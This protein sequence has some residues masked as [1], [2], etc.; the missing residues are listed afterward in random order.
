MRT[1]LRRAPERPIRS[2]RSCVRAPPRRRALTSAPGRTPVCAGDC[3]CSQPAREEQPRVRPDRQLPLPQDPRGRLQDLHLL[4]PARRRGERPRWRRAPAFRHEGDPGKPAP[5]RGRPHRQEGRYRGRKG[6]AREPRQG[7]GRD[8]LP[9]GSRADAGL[10]RR[11]GGGRP[12]GHARRHEDA[13]RRP[14][15]HQPA[16]P[17]RPRDRPL[18]HRGRVRHAQGLREECRARIRA[19]HGALQ[20]PEMGSGRLRELLGR[21]ARHRHLPPGQ[22][23]IP[24]ADRV[25]QAL[26]GGRDRARLPG[27]ARRHGLAHHDG[28]RARRA[29]LGRRRDRGRGRDAGPADLDADP[30]G[31][32]VQA[33]GE[34]ARG[35]DGDGPRAHRHPDAAQEGRRRQVRRV[36]RPRP[37]RPLGRGSRDDRQHGAR[38]RRDLWVLSDRR[39]D[40]RVSH[41]DEPHAGA[42]RAGR[43]LRQGAGHVARRDDARPRLHRH[44]G[45]RPRHRRALDGGSEAATGPG[46]AHRHQG[47]L[48]Q[49]HGGRVPQGG[50]VG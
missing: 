26:G 45:T 37:L 16:D 18:G 33:D 2:A 29:R 28:E 15:P 13:G 38:V 9:A 30:R 35:H 49:G 42:R 17:G 32:R 3:A 12:R 1:W 40:D 10:H 6:L 7:R 21:A 22:P 34:T 50:R 46:G 25:V 31:D 39:E 8:R 27:H 43:D 24:V 20:V 41:H 19:Q 23:R 47:L 44:A 11:P 36:L 5:V 4:F 48:H 14:A